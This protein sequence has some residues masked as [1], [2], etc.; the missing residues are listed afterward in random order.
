VAE[1]DLRDAERYL[2]EEQRLLKMPR[3]KIAGDWL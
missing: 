1:R 3:A 2:S